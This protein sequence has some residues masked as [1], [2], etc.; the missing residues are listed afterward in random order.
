MKK[1][2]WK[3][4]KGR[5]L[6]GMDSWT[7]T[8]CDTQVWSFDRPWEHEGVNRVYVT[9]VECGGGQANEP[10][11]LADCDAELVRLIMTS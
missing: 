3:Q 11:T 1:H 8:V 5:E 9:C 2:D 7:C 4:D 10:E 6:T